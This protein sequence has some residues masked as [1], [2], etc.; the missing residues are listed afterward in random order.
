MILKR[1][2]ILWYY[3]K[4]E[5][6]K[7]RRAMRDFYKVVSFNFLVANTDITLRQIAAS[8]LPATTKFVLCIDAITNLIKHLKPSGK[9]KNDIDSINNEIEKFKLEH[10]QYP[11]YEKGGIIGARN[12]AEDFHTIIE[13]LKAEIK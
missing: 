5:P 1:K 8:K 9:L 3:K 10:I 11:E 12:N 7:S 4:K 2:L 13:K 6:Y